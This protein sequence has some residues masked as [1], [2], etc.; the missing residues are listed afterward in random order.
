MGRFERIVYYEKVQNVQR[1]TSFLHK[2]FRM[3]AIS[4][5]TGATGVDAK[6][7]FKVV[8]QQEADRLESLVKEAGSTPVEVPDT[9]THF[10][11]WIKKKCNESSISH[12]HVKMS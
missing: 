1:R 3:T 10:V 11:K 4:F 7:E 6:V 9:D 12:Q 8:T 5:Q 2:I